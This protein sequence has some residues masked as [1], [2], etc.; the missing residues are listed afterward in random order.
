MFKR[1]FIYDF[2]L[3]QDDAKSELSALSLK[4]NDR[5]LCIAS[6]GEIPLELLVNSHESV[7][8]D[9][10]DIAASQIYLSRLKLKVAL[11]F[12][13]IQAAQF[14]GYMPAKETDRALW[15]HQIAPELT[16]TELKFW[17]NH[18]SILKYGPVNLGKYETY[19]RRFSPLGRLLLGGR[20]K[21]NGLFEARSIEEQKSYFD[22]ILR[23]GL[24]KNLFN[25]MFHPKLYKQRG[26]S[27]QG[28]IHWKDQHLGHKL[29]NQFRDFCTNTPVRENWMLQ[30]VLFNR[31]LF[32]ESLPDYLQ[33]KGISRLHEESERLRFRKESV[34]ESMNRRDA[35][36][37][38]KFA[39]SNVSDWLSAEDFTELLQIIAQKSGPDAKGLI[40]Y[41]HSARVT[42]LKL[43]EILGF[44]EKGGEKLLAEDRFPFY[45]LIPFSFRNHD[46][47]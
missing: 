7:M 30:F 20:K 2:G 26:I 14:L 41:I 11:H 21:L 8:I 38:N 5:V 24:L 17:M 42:D 13:R 39:L 40:R 23:A 19:I 29:Y 31:V 32:E 45:K 10:V 37:Y 43:P 12:E 16:E 25:V 6:A 34:T 15:F 9:A 35:G 47:I 28:L 18:L 4:E 46:K 3:A 27:E 44:D 33:P 22:E 36:Y 1:E